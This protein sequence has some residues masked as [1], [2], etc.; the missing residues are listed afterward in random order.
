MEQVSASRPKRSMVQGWGAASTKVQPVFP[1]TAANERP[2]EWLVEPL[3]FPEHQDG[4]H[5]EIADELIAGVDGEESHALFREQG[6]SE[7][8]GGDEA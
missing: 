7:L 2:G 3:L 5:D 4:S 8:D 1:D 6:S